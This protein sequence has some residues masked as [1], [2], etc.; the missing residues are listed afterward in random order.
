MRSR[1]VHRVRK[2][3]DDPAG[4]APRAFDEFQGAATRPGHGGSPGSGR[5]RARHAC[6]GTRAVRAAPRS[7]RGSMVS[8]PGPVV[9]LRVRPGVDPM[10][11]LRELWRRGTTVLLAADAMPDTARAGMMAAAGTSEEID[12]ASVPIASSDGTPLRAA[13]HPDAAGVLVS[14]SGSSGT[15]RLVELSLAALVSSAER[16]ATAVPFGPG[17]TWHASLAP[18]HVGGLMLHV[19]AAVLGGAVRHAPLPRTWAEVDGCTHVSLVAAQLARLLE[20]P[21]GPPRT[22]KA[23]MLGGGPSPAM[24]RRA[25]LSRGLPLFVTYGMTESASQVATCRPAMADADTLAGPPIP[26]VRI[27]A[28]SVAADGTGELTVDGP[29]LARAIIDG[30]RRLALTRPHRTRDA[31]FIDALGR[32]HVVGRLDAVINSGGRK[33]HPESIERTLCSVAGVR[34]ACVVGVA[35]PRWGQRPVAFV[36]AAEAA[37]AAIDRAL[38]AVHPPH[39][40]PDAILRMPDDE[41]GAMKPS[42]ARLAARLA[43]GE[44]FDAFS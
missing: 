27:E 28:D 20:D 25:A 13:D 18:H 24:L 11:W 42:R 36:D 2:L 15:P 17:D 9:A 44:R 39:E 41:A 12:A 43:A 35:H 21:A 29:V 38:R 10:P 32:I 30:G 31:G 4:R 40:M 33:V 5:V 8:G 23:V 37:A 22:L 34:A 7:A 6:L 26:G 1:A 16:G 14:T 3:V 19:R